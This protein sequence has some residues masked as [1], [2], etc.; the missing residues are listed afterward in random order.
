MRTDV[1]IAAAVLCFTD[2]SALFHKK[3][4]VFSKS[5]TEAQKVKEIKKRIKVDAT[6]N[7]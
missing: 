4:K 3:G 2:V 6:L 7:P 1:L 5:T